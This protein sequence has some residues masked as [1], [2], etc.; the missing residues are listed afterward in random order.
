MSYRKESGKLG[1]SRYLTGCTGL[2]TFS[3]P[4]ACCLMLRLI[5]GL[6]TD[7]AYAQKEPIILQDVKSAIQGELVWR[8]QIST[9]ILPA[10]DA[11]IVHS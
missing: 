10:G 1:K 9:A 11:V 6:D 3:H 2:D 5:C 4:L 8:R 7:D